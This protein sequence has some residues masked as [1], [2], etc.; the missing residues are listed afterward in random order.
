M[1]VTPGNVFWLSHAEE[2]E[3]GLLS[4]NHYMLWFGPCFQRILVGIFQTSTPF[5]ELKRRCFFAAMRQPERLAGAGISSRV[6]ARSGTEKASSRSAG[7]GP[8]CAPEPPRRGPRYPRSGSA[9]AT[10]E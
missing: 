2:V 6:S 3:G 8:S 4:L 10:H 7:R 1:R 9:R 5:F